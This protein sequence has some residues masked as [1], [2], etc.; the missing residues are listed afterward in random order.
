[1]NMFNPN[2]DDKIWVRMTNKYK[3]TCGFCNRAVEAGDPILWSKEKRL[4]TH[5]PEMCTFLGIRKKKVSIREMGT[6]PRAK[7]TNPRAKHPRKKAKRDPSQIYNFPVT[8]S[9]VK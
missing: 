7:G 1:M 3:N 8:V 2:M 4:I 9:Y 5:L 6:N